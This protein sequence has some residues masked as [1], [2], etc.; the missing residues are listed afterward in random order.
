MRVDG[1]LAALLVA[2]L[3]AAPLA[4]AA[5]PP[6]LARQLERMPE[7][8]R[9]QV[10][11]RQA[12]LDAMTPDARAA[13]HA[14]RVAWDSLPLEARA[15]LREHWLAWQALPPG[16]QQALREATRAFAALPAERQ[17]ALRQEFAKLSPDEQ[18]G[19]LLGPRVGAHWLQLQPLMMQVPAGE[20]AKLLAVLVSMEE[21]QLRDLAI[22]AHRTPPQ[23]RAA[24]RRD[25]LETTP[26]NRGAWLQLRLEH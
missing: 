9:Q 24:L 21:A 17:Q 4:W 2:V 3:V 25:L 26:A 12:R 1:R 7:A 15:R 14:R 20:R 11:Q 22:L 13:L 18:R 5:L 6:D 10:L 19:W 8:L 16:Q 23:A